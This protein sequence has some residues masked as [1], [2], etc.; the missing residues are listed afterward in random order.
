M[1]NDVP[2]T[3]EQESRQVAEQARQTEWEG[4]GFVRD[5]FLGKFG[6][7]LI[8]PFPREREERPQFTKYYTELQ[9]FI[10]DNVD[11]V[12]IDQTGEYPEAV[13]DGLRK[14]GAFGMKI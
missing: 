10:R 2:L 6:V 7:D 8:Y 13:V 14:L 11:S 3:S 1:A 4:K 9:D 12:A 5:L